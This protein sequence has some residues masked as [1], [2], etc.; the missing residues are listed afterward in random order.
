[1]FFATISVGFGSKSCFI[2]NSD[3]ASIVAQTIVSCLEGARARGAVREPRAMVIGSCLPMGGHPF[4]EQFVG[5]LFPLE[6]VIVN[7]NCLQHAPKMRYVGSYVLEKMCM[8]K[9]VWT[10]PVHTDCM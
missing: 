8:R 6:T 4:L 10:A 2:I 5:T 7:E 9:C 3:N 1:M